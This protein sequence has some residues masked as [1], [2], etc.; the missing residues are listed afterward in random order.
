M[1][2]DTSST[3]YSA[4][5]LGNLIGEAPGSP[6]IT[7]QGDVIG[8]DANGNIT[9]T[10]ASSNPVAAVASGIGDLI[11]WIENAGLLA[12]LAAVAIVILVVKALVR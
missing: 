11:T 2:G 8:A 3:Q 10:P 12:E 7:N 4:D 6:F 1:N 5:A 9:V